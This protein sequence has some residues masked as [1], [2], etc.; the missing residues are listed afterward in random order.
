VR[1]KGADH[2][3]ADNDER[4]KKGENDDEETAHPAPWCPCCVRRDAAPVA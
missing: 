4:Q 1:R 3:E 2:H